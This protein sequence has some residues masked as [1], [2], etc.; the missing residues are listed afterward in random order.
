MI[1]KPRTSPY[2]FQGLGKKGISI[3][4][5]IKELYKLPLIVEVI[6]PRDINYVKEVA[7]I[8]QVGARNMQNFPLLKEVGK[9][10][11]PIILK[12]GF[13]AT[14]EEWLSSAEYI[15]SMGNDQIIL[16]ERGIRSF[17]RETRFTLDI[18]VVPV[19]KKLTKLPVIV[20]P[21]HAS[22]TRDLV[23]ACARASKAVGADGLIIEVHPNPDKALS[24]NKQQ[25][26]FKLFKKLI[27]ELK[28]IK[29]YKNP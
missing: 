24:D 10:N 21:S 3:I 19:I 15:L 22:G 9:L 5:K 1:F 14:V 17:S 29:Y 2:S 25:L 28:E 16:C 13:A 7:D 20:D 4:K 26:T 12:R 8:I 27:K 23:I 6:D 11:K 18:S